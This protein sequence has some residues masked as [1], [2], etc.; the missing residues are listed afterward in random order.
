MNQVR[1]SCIHFMEQTLDL[2]NCLEFY[3]LADEH[4]ISDLKEELKLT[5]SSRLQDPSKDNLPVSPK[6]LACITYLSEA[7]EYCGIHHML[8]CCSLDCSRPI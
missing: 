6:L 2:D 7:F 3:G 5:T 1:E 4:K 8:F